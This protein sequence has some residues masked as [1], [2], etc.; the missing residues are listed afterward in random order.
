[1]ALHALARNHSE[2]QGT[3]VNEQRL[4]CSYHE[5]AHL[6]AQ[7]TYLPD[8]ELRVPVNLFES[9]WVAGLV[10]AKGVVPFHIEERD[11]HSEV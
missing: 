4:V 8:V 9:A 7:P 1:M 6:G 10:G 2:S 5:A 11:E 3:G